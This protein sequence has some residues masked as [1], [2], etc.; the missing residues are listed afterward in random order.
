MIY[1]G[2]VAVLCAIAFAAGAS[3]AWAEGD[4]YGEPVPVGPP[5]VYTGPQGGSPNGAAGRYSDKGFATPAPG[6]T[7]GGYGSVPD[8]AGE[9]YAEAEYV[10]G[11]PYGRTGYWQDG[12]GGR[13]GTQFGPGYYQKGYYHPGERQFPDY[14]QYDKERAGPGT[15]WSFVYNGVIDPFVPDQR[16][17]DFARALPVR[18][19]TKSRIDEDLRRLQKLAKEAQHDSWAGG[20]YDSPRPMK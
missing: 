2:R 12:R 7:Q 4:A 11:D 18:I 17:I 10:N 8:D 3:E 6:S 1:A 5:V 19:I 14:S 20:E 13:G 16:E 15:L 9:A